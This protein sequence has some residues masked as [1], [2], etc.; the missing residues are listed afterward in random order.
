M[1]GS[2]VAHPA[3]AFERGEAGW[4]RGEGEEEEEGRGWRAACTTVS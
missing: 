4:S 2:R 3:G 1:T